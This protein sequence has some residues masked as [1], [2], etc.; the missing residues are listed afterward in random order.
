MK[1]MIS[2]SC[3]RISRRKW[4]SCSR[5]KINS[6]KRKGKEGWPAIFRG[7]IV[8]LSKVVRNSMGK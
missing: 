2:K 5:S 4:S 7:T 3:V 6:L 1:K 8:V